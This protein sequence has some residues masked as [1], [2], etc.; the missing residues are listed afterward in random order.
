MSFKLPEYKA[1]DFTKEPFISAP[2]I[3]TEKVTIKGVAPD[4]Y[5]ATSIYPEYFKIDE[6]WILASESRMDCVV[7][8]KDDKSLDIKEFRNLNIGDNVVLGRSENAEDGIYVH[9]SGFTYTESEEEQSFVFR[10]GRTRESSYSKDYDS[11]Y[12]LL[13][14]ER[15]N[16]YI[17]WVLGPAVVFDHD[18][19]N[20]MSA[21]INAGYVDTIFAGNALATHDLEGSIL[22]TALGQDIYTQ[23]SVFNGHYNHIDVINRARRAGSLEKFIEQE[24]ITEGVVYSCIKNNVPLVL[25]GSIRDDGPLP[26]VIANVY[27]A[28]DAMRTHSKKATTVICLA[29]Q[30]H[31]IATGNMTPMYKVE[32][33][34]IR[35]VY[36]YTVDISEFG[37]NKLR[38][39]GSLEVTSIVT[40][41]QDFLVNIKNNLV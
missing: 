34:K 22:K 9:V 1:P 26:P 32:E 25:A 30:L 21:L 35:P 17:L 12:E 8:V 24:N 41:V 13:K 19:K 39:R 36:I 6:K 2:N 14:Y 16:G 31:T 33:D 40:N 11:L 3:I 7:V 15:E 20:A 37:V 27:D 28:Q 5:H 29:T 10:T 18:S 4:K 23:H 38:D